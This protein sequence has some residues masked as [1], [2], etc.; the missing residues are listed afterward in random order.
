MFFTWWACS[1]YQRPSL[2]GGLQQIDLPAFV[3]PDLLEVADGESL[4]GGAHF[5]VAVAPDGV[6]IV[7]LRKHFQ[8]FRGASRHN[9]DHSTGQIAGFEDLVKIAGDERV[10]FRR[11]SHHRVSGRDQRE[12]QRE[13]SE[14]RKFRGANHADCAQRFIHRDRNVAKRRVVHRAIKLVRPSCVGEQPL[15]ALVHFLGRLLFSNGCREPRGDFFAA[16]RKILGDVIEHLR[17]VVRRG[18]APGFRLARG[19]HGIAN[20]LAVAERR[21]AQQ[22]TFLA[23]NFQ[24]VARNPA[25]PACRRCRAS[26]CGQCRAW[27]LRFALSC[28]R[29]FSFNAELCGTTPAPDIPPALPGRLRVH[30]RFRDSRRSRTRRRTGSC[31][32]PTPR[33][34]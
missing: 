20:V 3:G 33:R 7:V 12:H 21:F 26:P 27:P 16:L 15:D 18:L 17:A 13:K 28:A 9:V 8:Q 34:P 6:E 29:H 25:A 14:Q 11:H 22:L 19:F 4:G 24:A 2:C 23:A 30:S 5:R 1:R 31:C 10:R 32:S